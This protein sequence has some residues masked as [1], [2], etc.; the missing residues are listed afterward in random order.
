MKARDIAMKPPVVIQGDATLEQA[1]LLIDAR[2][3]GSL[4]VLDG[5]RLVGIVT[6]RDIVVRGVARA[7]SHTARIDSVMST[8]VATIG[9]DADL[10]EAY[11]RIGTAGA[12]RLPVVEGERIVGVLTVDDLLL[13]SVTDLERL[14][15]PVVGELAFGHHPAPVPA[16]R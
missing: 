12:R 13:H 5:E 7:Y 4:L 2:N 11:R 16:V 3:V 8:D 9:A 15:H 6:D 1:A 10:E 14:A